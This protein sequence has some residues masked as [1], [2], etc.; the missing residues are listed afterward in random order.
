M[1]KIEKGQLPLPWLPVLQMTALSRT[2][3]GDIKTIEK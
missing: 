1:N 2:S 3:A